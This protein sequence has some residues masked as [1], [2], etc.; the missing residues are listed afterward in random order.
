MAKQQKKSLNK[1]TR[2]KQISRRVIFKHP[3]ITL[4]EDEVELPRGDKTPYLLFGLGGESVTI[5]CVRNDEVLL[6]QEYSYPPDEV[7]FQFPGG[8]IEPGELLEDAARRELIEE[9]QL[10]P[11]EVGVLGWYYVNNRRSDAKMHVVIARGFKENRTLTGDNEE[12]IISSWVPIIEFEKMIRKGKIV[13]YSVLAAW[14][15]YNARQ[16]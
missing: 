13:N 12:D 16:E 3:R 15:L 1:N 2:W 9:S 8:K 6:Q 4:I 11:E 14:A 7:L 5:I 10:E